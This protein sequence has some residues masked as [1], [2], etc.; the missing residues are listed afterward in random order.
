MLRLIAGTL[1]W[2]G[3]GI[4]IAEVFNNLEMFQFKLNLWHALLPA[5][6]FLFTE[7]LIK[8][9]VLKKR[10][11]ADGKYARV[12]RIYQWILGLIG[13]IF[14]ISI[15]FLWWEVIKKLAQTHP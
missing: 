14:L 2:A 5:G 11:A 15:P 1:G 13:F 3:L 9:M 4:I 8:R 12:R 7:L 10:L 6:I